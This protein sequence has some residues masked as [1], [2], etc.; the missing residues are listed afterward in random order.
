MNFLD[1]I[2]KS[3]PP[4]PPIVAPDDSH[5]REE[6]YRARMENA[7]ATSALVDTTRKQTKQAEFT[8]QVIQGV[9]HRVDARRDF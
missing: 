6:L 3:A 2:F 7:A 4:A 9:L 1:R 5:I 8:R